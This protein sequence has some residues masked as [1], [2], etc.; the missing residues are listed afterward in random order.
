MKQKREK[1]VASMVIA[2][3]IFV[4]IANFANAYEDTY[5]YRDKCPEGDYPPPGASVCGNEWERQ[6][7]GDIEGG[8][9]EANCPDY[10]AWTD[11]WHFAQCEC[12]SYVAHKTNEQF[13]NWGGGTF[14]NSYLGP[15]W[16]HAYTWGEKCEKN[17]KGELTNCK[18]GGAAAD[19]GIIMD[20]TPLPGDAAWWA[21]DQIGGGYGHIAWVER[22][23]FDNNG[24]WIS[25]DI[26]DY[27]GR[28]DHNFRNSVNFTRN[29]IG[30]DGSPTAF[31]HILLD[32]IGVIGYIDGLEMSGAVGVPFSNQTPE[33]RGW[34]I[35]RQLVGY[36]NLVGTSRQIAQANAY[37]NDIGFGGGTI[38]DTPQTP[39]Y[40]ETPAT[41]F[42]Y[43]KVSKEDKDDWQEEIELVIGKDFDVK[44]KFNEN[45]GSEEIEG[46]VK[47]YLS[48]DS[49]FDKDEDEELCKE[50]FT[51]EPGEDE[52]EECRSRTVPVDWG[53]GN[54]YLFCYVRW[55]DEKFYADN[56]AVVKIRNSEAGFVQSGNQKQINR[57]I[58]LQ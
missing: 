33:E 21:H 24:N 7:G 26:S 53:D 12:T 16:G 50:E 23:Y 17:Y 8:K 34:L 47:F 19:S 13:A 57:S 42:K 27:N 25:V 39:S 6:A 1:R 14:S 41:L 28:G 10:Y 35:S 20:T 18:R 22:V 5:I 37:Y 43:I 55:G 2:C 3:L 9:W 30:T 56:Y 11:R 44:V 58:L 15:H 54:Y 31:I 49:E 4:L 51:M 29:Q 36:T 40:S 38:P 48:K 46:Y 52:S 45:P 32:K